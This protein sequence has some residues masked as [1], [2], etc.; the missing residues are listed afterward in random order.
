M[1]TP[2]AADIQ[3]WSDEVARDPRS[4]AFLPLA[5]AYRRQGLNELAM[6][7]CLRGLEAY[8]SHAEAHGLLAL[9]YLEAGD[10][11]RAADEWSMVLRLD[12]DNFDALRGMGFCYLEQD[13][14]SRARHTLERAALLRPSD[15]AVQEA[16]RLLGTRQQLVEKGIADRAGDGDPRT[17]GGDAAATA[18]DETGTGTGETPSS[19]AGVA[20]EASGTGTEAQAATAEP[21]ASHGPAAA[22]SHG[23]AVAAQDTRADP[24]VRGPGAALPADPAE[25]FDELLG[26][27]PLLGALLVDPQGLVLAGRLHAEGGGDAVTLGAVLGGAVDEAGRTVAL[28]QL[29]AWGGILLEAEHALLHLTPAA[30]SAVVVLAAKRSTP[31]GWMLRAA[32]QAAAQAA[33]YLEAYA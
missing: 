29:G 28:L 7:L 16:L 9:L 25:L 27:G 13:Q 17:S 12:P 10:R 5:R 21:A 4:L 3:R 26:S 32:A 11:Q 6:Q 33:R 14:L 30:G 15:V 19:T 23:P 20:A 31:H 22:A 24:I 1:K 8:P 18:A 2:A